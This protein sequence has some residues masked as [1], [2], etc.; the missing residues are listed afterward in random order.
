MSLSLSWLTTIHSR[1]LAQVRPI[2]RSLLRIDLSIIPDFRWDEKVR[3]TAETFIILVE[4]V[5]GEII[6]F[7]DSFGNVTQKTSTT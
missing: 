2:T 1:L 7:H 3:G 5:D 4:D 6:F